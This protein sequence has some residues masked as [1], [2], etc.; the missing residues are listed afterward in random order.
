MQNFGGKTKSIMVFL[1]VAYG[2]TSEARV[3]VVR[4]YI[5]QKAQPLSRQ[6]LYSKD[7][8]MQWL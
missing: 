4:D 7:V 6:A 1:K 5:K 8:E 3:E 2:D